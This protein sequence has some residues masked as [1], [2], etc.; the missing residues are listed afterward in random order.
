MSEKQ[1]SNRRTKTVERHR[2]ETVPLAGSGTE[3]LEEE[4]SQ[5]VNGRCEEREQEG[6]DKGDDG[7]E[8][9]PIAPRPEAWTFEGKFGLEEAER[10]FNL[11]APGIGVEDLPGV[12]GRGDGLVGQEVPGR[13]LVRARDDQPERLLGMLGMTHWKVEDAYFAVTTPPRVPQLAMFEGAFAPAHLTR[14]TPAL[15]IL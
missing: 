5:S 12:L 13:A 6:I 10:G 9:E 7:K 2:G 8:F 15:G 3:T 14:G 4:F 11:P 1:A